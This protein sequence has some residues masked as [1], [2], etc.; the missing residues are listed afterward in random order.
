M[1]TITVSDILEYTCP[2]LSGHNVYVIRDGE[3][4]FYVGATWNPNTRL[5]QHFGQSN[6]F[7]YAP[8]YELGFFQANE[9]E[10]HGWQI[11]LYTL[12][13][14]AASEGIAVNERWPAKWLLNKM[15]DALILKFSPTFNYG[16][17]PNRKVIPPHYRKR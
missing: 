17:L 8:L 10:S 6:E 2:N 13:E 9:P 5:M 16:L 14:V 3:F 11:D 15:E 7:G 1:I 12:E 4:V